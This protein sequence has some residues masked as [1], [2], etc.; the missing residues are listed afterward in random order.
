MTIDQ[1][2]DGV[3]ELADACQ[4][5]V[6]TPEDEGYAEVS[7]PWNLAFAHR[8]ALVVRAATETD[9]VHAVRHAAAHGLGVA[10]QSTGH[11]VSLPADGQS[12]LISTVD[13]DQVH[14]DPVART[15]T[16][17]GG[18]TW[19]PVLAA[20]QEHGLAPLLGS[21][22][23]IG[24]VGYSLGGGSGWLARKH[25]LG[26]DQI[27]S[28]RVV[29]ADGHVVTASPSEEPELFWALCGSAGGVLGV[30]VEMTVGLAPVADVYAG[31][32]F[33]PVEAAGEV[34]DRYLDWAG[35][36]PAELTSAFTLMAFPP[37]DMVPEPLRGQTFAIVRG[38]YAGD[39]GQDL[40]AASDLVD[41]LRAW[42]APV[43]DTWSVM[44]FARSEE[45]SMDPVDPLPGATS[46]RWLARLDR[47]VFEAM[48]EALVGGDAPSPML[49]A[50]VRHSGGA[51]AAPNSQVSFEGRDGGWLLELVGIVAGPGAAEDLAHRFETV[52]RRVDRHLAS[53]SG[54]L[55]FVEGTDRARCASQAFSGQTLARLAACKRRFD[56][57]DLFRFG[58]PL[59]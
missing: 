8:P 13:L 7:Q 46:G 51:T 22:P 10:V 9:V 20:G 49:L 57:D 3:Q 38:C 53:T 56:P 30:V 12:V 31:N 37:M 45:I 11:G 54:Y 5:P 50:E 32:L 47:T 4:G 48:L 24:V 2:V 36:A 6:L 27:R 41:E 18:A 34:F 19:R 58:I 25:G 14:V 29:L 21:A 44:P 33:Y 16:V 40:G 26:V 23:D 1:S 28:M 52:W 17:G 35:R 39:P 59:A 15:A 55:N 43:M 42:R